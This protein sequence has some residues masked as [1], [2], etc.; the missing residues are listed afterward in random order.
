MN[1]QSLVD[2]VF[3]QTQKALRDV[4]NVIDSV[5]DELWGASYC[6]MPLWK[7]IYHMLQTLE[8]WYNDPRDKNNI[9]PYFGPQGFNG[10][11]KISKRQMPK[12]E[13]QDYYK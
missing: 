12:I 3:D 13:M 5:P 2:V 11:A 8:Q 6:E 1:Q 9:K 7:H 10:L 4:E